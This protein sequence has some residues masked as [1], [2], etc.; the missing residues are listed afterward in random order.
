MRLI[1]NAPTVFKGSLKDLYDQFSSK[2]I[3][4]ENEVSKF[5][6]KLVN[7][8]KS[9]DPVFLIRT[10]SGLDRETVFRNHQ[11]NQIY[12]TDNAPAWWIHYQLFNRKM[13]E[14]QSFAE[15]ISKVPTKM[16]NIGLSHH[17]NKAGWYVAH[18]FNAKD[19]R[20]NYN[21]WGRTE[22][23]KRMI[24]N[25]HPCN[26]FYF[27]KTG[28]PRSNRYGEDPKVIGYFREQYARKYKDIW[29]EFMVLIGEDSTIPIDDQKDYFV[30]IPVIFNNRI[31]DLPQSR[32]GISNS[33]TSIKCVYSHSRLCFLADKIEPLAMDDKFQI[34]S[35]AG[36]FIM[37][38]HEFYDC[39]PN[40]VKSESYQSDRIYHYS[41]VPQKALRFKV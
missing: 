30:E 14:I 31:P 1:P 39:F 5:H 13:D 3:L 6:H 27:P 34:N 19:G 24:R 35:K 25:I 8:L 33:A 20:T 37:T 40:V 26:Y 9:S 17:I 12:P 15:F 10:V 29:D 2:V 4:D 38:K 16:F 22:L 7:Y 36:V 23:T 28:E 11:G 18:K 41:S 21:S 32:I